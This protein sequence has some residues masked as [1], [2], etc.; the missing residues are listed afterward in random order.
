[1]LPGQSLRLQNRPPPVPLLQERCNTSIFGEPFYRSAR[2][3]F[4][5]FS[6]SYA[7]HTLHRLILPTN[8][9][10]PGFPVATCGFDDLL[11]ALLAGERHTWSSLA[12]RT[13]KS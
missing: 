8:P 12:A 10:K 2:S 7:E 5:E 13:R 11:A 3:D 1:M 4:A 9:G 6:R